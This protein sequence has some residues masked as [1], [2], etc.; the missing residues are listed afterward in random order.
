[1]PNI[2][3]TA[4]TT[5]NAKPEMVFVYV[6]D[7]M[8]HSEWSANPLT[9]EAVSISPKIIGNQYRSI[10]V[11]NGI[12]LNA[13]LHVTDYQVPVRFG[14][15]GQDP[16]GKFSHQFTFASLN[17]ETRVVR[18]INFTLSKRQWVMFL[19]LYFPVRRPAAKKALRLLKQRL[20][21]PI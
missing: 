6:A 18:Q 5:V 10:A 7:L 19:M 3:L 14:F 2:S 11:V 15:E 8:K 9:I 17:N 20:E 4:S 21:Q 1:M 13:E 12:T 16:T